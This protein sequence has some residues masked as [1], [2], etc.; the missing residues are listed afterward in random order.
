MSQLYHV[1]LVCAGLVAAGCHS[2][3][4]P[5]APP[6]FQV[7]RPVRQT[8]S[9][10][11][12]YVGQLRSPQHIELR[13]LERGYIQHI[14]VDEGQAVKRGQP[15]FQILPTLYQAE[16]QKAGAEA[17][18]ARLE[19]E[20]TRALAEQNIV[21]PGE[22]K[23]G[24]ARRD[25]ALAELQLARVHR[26]FTEVK[27]PFDGIMGRLSVRPGSL[28]SEGEL[29]TTLS[30]N[31]RMW[32][33][34]NVA[35]AEYLDL[36]AEVKDLSIPVSLV[37]ANGRP[38]DQPGRVETIEA[39]FDSETGTIAFRATFPNPTGLLRHGETGRVVLTQELPDALLIPQ[40]AV[41]EVL[42]KR[43]VYVVD[44]Q[45]VAR[46]REIQVSHELPHLFVLSDGLADEEPLLL[47]SV[48]KVRN[49]ETVAVS[50]IEPREALAHLDVPAE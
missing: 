46:A 19:Y 11:R 48:S 20:N 42:D 24:A 3:H 40:K 31:S 27:A 37:M 33:Y 28:V 47:E 18:F 4:K 23:L 10:D 35:E 44:A 29:L 34:F 41:F 6:V 1:T 21:S 14:Y 43:F 49:G 5:A 26:D 7:T 16:L 45:H 32:V 50:F 36:R 25:K 39:D 13:A 8:T 38:F 22:L 17:E 30:N 2:E 12:S 9:L 15:M